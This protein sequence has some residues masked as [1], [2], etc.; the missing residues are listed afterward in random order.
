MDSPNKV[1]IR[2]YLEE[3]VNI[4]DLERVAEFVASPI[5]EAEKQHIRGVRSTYPDLHVGVIRQIEQGDL[6]ASQVV[7]CATHKQ[8][9]RGIKPTYKSIV[10]DAVTLT[11]W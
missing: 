10:I 9:W 2:R 4:G 11:A 8:K 3:V 6:I 7:A 1:L 5:I